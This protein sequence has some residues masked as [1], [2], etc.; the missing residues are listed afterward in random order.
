MQLALSNHISLLHGWVPMAVEVV[1][2]IALG[3]AVG[4]RSRRWRLLWLPL[5]AAV[6]GLAAFGTYWSVAAA[7]LDTGPAPHALYVWIALA[8]M[9]A[10]VA[11]LGWRGARWWRRGAAVLAVPL[12]LLCSLLVLNQWVGYFQTVQS[13]W[14]QLTSRPLPDQSDGATVATMAAK[15]IKPTHGSLVPVQ[16]PSDASHFKHREELVY[17]PPAWFASYPPPA[18]PTVMMIG[19]MLSSPADWV[20][21]G[22]AVESADAFAAAHGGNAP[23][24]VFVDAGGAF[25]NDTECVNGSRGN[26]AD[27]LTKDVV[28]YLVSN[29]GVSADPSHWGVVGWSM[30]GTCAVD[31]TVMH[32]NLFNAFV[33]IEG[34]LTPNTGTKAQTIANLFGGNADTWAAFDPTTVI[35]RHGRYTGVSGWFAISSGGSPTPNRDVTTV[36]SAA[37]AVAGRGAAADPGNQAAAAGSLCALGRANGVDCAVVAHAG[38]H[39]WPTAGAVFTTAL[40]WL[41]GRLGTPGVARIALPGMASAADRRT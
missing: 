18:L 19:G 20:R 23:V 32:P 22:N 8:G 9:A 27:H 17:L 33:D 14:N 1:T 7:G 28:P 37:M 21:A 41:A 26:A 11:I 36:D 3:L 34:D 40:P 5:A 35:A 39:D 6:G 4:W 13:A 15:G 12:C 10:A 29:F 2:A 31:L 16:I 30:G 25:D 38:K 24:L